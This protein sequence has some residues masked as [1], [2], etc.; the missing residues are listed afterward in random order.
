MNKIVLKIIIIGVS[1]IISIPILLML[2]ADLSLGGPIYKFLNNRRYIGEP[3]I[4][5]TKNL[6]GNEYLI[7]NTDIFNGK[8]HL[9]INLEPKDIEELRKQH[10]PILFK[11]NIEINQNGNS[12]LKEYEFKI[13]GATIGFGPF[14]IFEIPK[15][16]KK[17][18]NI[19]IIFKD[20]S[21][22][23]KYYKR[24]KFRVNKS[25]FKFRET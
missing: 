11:F 13:D 2:F 12:L 18:N 17:R 6:N 5:E 1:V 3:I 4:I 24:I 7:K 20:I 22:D 23:T 19:T 9:I 25:N 14:V 10:E 15:D 8:Y 16:I 21:I